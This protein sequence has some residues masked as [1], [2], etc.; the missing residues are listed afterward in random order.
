MK[1][2]RSTYSLRKRL[3]AVGAVLGACGLVLVARAA[4]LQLISPD[5][6]QQ[7]GDARFLRDVP[8]ATSRGMITDRNGEPLAV[9]SPVESVWVCCSTPT[10]CRPWPVRWTFRATCSSSGWRSVRT[11]SSCTCAGT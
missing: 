7:Q 8:I 1:V 6:Y 5:F 10:A 11:R 9:S 2:Q 4:H 3:M